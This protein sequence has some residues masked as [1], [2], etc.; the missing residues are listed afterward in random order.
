[1]ISFN[2]KMLLGTAA[3]SCS[4]ILYSQTG[5]KVNFYSG[6]P[7]NYV[8]QDS[9][10]LYFSS[11]NL[12][13]APAA[14]SATTTLPIALIRSIV[15]D[16]SLLEVKETS[17]KNSLLLVP[18]PSSNFIRISDSKSQKL[19]VEIFSTTGQK[20]LSGEYKTNED[21]YIGHL[22]A[23]NYVVQANGLTTKLIKK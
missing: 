4:S 19:Q 2:I 20:V 18:N 6:T 22:T 12:V 5:I 7:Q 13:I 3:L 11:D 21:I 9:G 17:L 15:F 8:I 1:M 23:G 16:N 14:N 10:K